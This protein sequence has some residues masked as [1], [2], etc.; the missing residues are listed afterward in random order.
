MLEN[1]IDIDKVAENPGLLPYAHHVGSALIKPE[2]RGKIKSRA[3]TAMY[4]Q[5]DLQMKNIHEQI[6]LLAEQAKN[7]K[8]RIE[9]S[10]QIYS[11]SMRFEPIVGHYYHLYKNKDGSVSLSLIGPT[12]W[13]K[14]CPFEEHLSTVKLLADHTWEIIG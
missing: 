11:A 10:E 4:E 5:T 7:I 12:E 8:K 3:L 13:G 6:Q 1:P 9:V 14:S 2:D